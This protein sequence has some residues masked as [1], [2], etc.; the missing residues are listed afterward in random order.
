MRK[1]RN[2]RIKKLRKAFK[3]LDISYCK[4]CCSMTHTIKNGS[5]IIKCGKCG[6]KKL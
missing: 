6:E 4:N 5:G 1:S 2:Q 3:E